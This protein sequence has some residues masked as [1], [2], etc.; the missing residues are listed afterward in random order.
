VLALLPARVKA[1][2]CNVEGC[3]R[4]GKIVHGMCL[5]H[6]NRMTGYGR[7]E[8]LPPMLIEDRLWSHVVDQPNGC[9]EWAG[10][11]ANG[12][13]VININHKM[14]GTHRLAWT[15]VNG[16][17]PDGLQVLHH[18][19]NPPCCQTNPTEGYPE[20]HLFLGTRSDNMTDMMA[21]GR[22]P[23]QDATHCPRGHPYAGQN[24][25]VTPQGWRR[26][27]TCNAAAGARWR[28]QKKRRLALVKAA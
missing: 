25:Y 19:D 16:P 20:G 21:K 1:T 26:C 5:T 24:L 10:G 6:Y 4:G 8:L 11:K 14:T 13:G 28:Q 27:R 15:L 7:T 23:G 9:R 3:D 12:Y 2:R 17:I 18:C 22:G